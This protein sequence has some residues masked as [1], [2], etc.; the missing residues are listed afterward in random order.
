MRPVF[1]VLRADKRRVRDFALREKL[2]GGFVTSFFFY[3]E[4]LFRFFA[5]VFVYV[6][7]RDEFRGFIARGV[8]AEQLPA[9]TES[10]YRQF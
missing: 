1:R 3:A 9:V 8:L 6:R 5:R 4:L 7:N 2:F 10:Y